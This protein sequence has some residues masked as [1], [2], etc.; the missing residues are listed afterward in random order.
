MNQQTPSARVQRNS[1]VIAGFGQNMVLTFVSTFLLLY[2]SEYA[3]IS[4]GGARDC[5][6]DP[7]GGKGV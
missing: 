3:K 5:R 6:G 7:R 2:L 1:I 4:S